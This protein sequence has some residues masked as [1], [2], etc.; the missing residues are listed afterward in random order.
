MRFELGVM[1]FRA[2][3][4]QIATDRRLFMH[5]CQNWSRNPAGLIRPSTNRHAISRDFEERERR[6]SNPRPPA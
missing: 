6:D 5:P 2:K 3:S 1:Q 4:A